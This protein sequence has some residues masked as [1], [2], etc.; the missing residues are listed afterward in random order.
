MTTAR[1]PCRFR[2][3]LLRDRTSRQSASSG[4]ANRRSRPDRSRP[5]A[6]RAC[7]CRN[8]AA[9]PSA[10]KTGW[11]PGTVSYSSPF[12]LNAHAGRIQP[13]S[14]TTCFKTCFNQGKIP[15]GA[16]C[17]FDDPIST[18]GYRRP[19]STDGLPTP[20]PVHRPRRG[21]PDTPADGRPLH[22]APA[23]AYGSPAPCTSGCAAGPPP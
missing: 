8:P 7:R 13:A 14:C 15:P 12:R 16:G 4:D 23:A 9:F 5:A 21:S 20:C 11:V 6:H 17:C 2:P 1:F 19:V 10:R 18:D 22:P 3:G